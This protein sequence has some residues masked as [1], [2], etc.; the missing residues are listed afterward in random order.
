MMTTFSV[1]VPLV[2]ILFKCVYLR[3]LWIP[4]AA[5]LNNVGFMDRLCFLNLHQGYLIY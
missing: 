1:W 3:I 4:C 5:D 2:C